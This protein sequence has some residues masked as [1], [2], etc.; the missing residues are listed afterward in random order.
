MPPEACILRYGR[1]RAK[2]SK[3]Q[4]GWLQAVLRTGPCSEARTTL[5]TF[6]RVCQTA[7]IDPA[8]FFM[9]NC[10]VS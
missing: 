6:S 1:V 3:P 10:R 4:G 8:A 7:D 5:L 9:I 2:S